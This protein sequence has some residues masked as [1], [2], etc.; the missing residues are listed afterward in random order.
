M[1]DLLQL[2]LHRQN[3]AYLQL[4]V[5]EHGRLELVGLQ[6]RFGDEHPHDFGSSRLNIVGKSGE[7]I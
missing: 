4:P 6:A 3:I 5:S 2:L 1:G 7:T